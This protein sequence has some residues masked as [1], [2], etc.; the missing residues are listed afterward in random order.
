VILHRTPRPPWRSRQRIVTV[1]L[2]LVAAAAAAAIAIAVGTTTSGYR[3][4]LARNA[5]VVKTIALTGTVEPV[6]RVTLSFGVSGTVATVAVHIGQRVGAGQTVAT[7]ATT[8]LAAQVTED[9][10]TL[11][12]AQATVTADEKGQ[13]G[14]GAS[15]GPVA[16]ATSGGGP[17][18]SS[19]TSGT[20]SG[21]GT[22]TTLKGAQRAVVAAQK[23]ADAAEQAAAAALSTADTACGTPPPTTST[24]TGTATG[25]GTATGPTATTTSSSTSPQS[26]GTGTA[27]ATALHDA[28]AAQQTLAA[29]QR[30]VT[31]AESGLANV[32]AKGGSPTGP[33]TKPATGTTATTPST[34]G[35]PGGTGASS[36]TTPKDAAAQ[37]ASDQ[38]TVDTDDANLLTAQQSL[39]EATL[40]SPIS[41]TVGAVNIS[42]GDQTNGGVSTAAVTIV[43]QHTFEAEGLVSPTQVPALAVGDAVG[44]TVDGRPSAIAGH[45]TRIGPVDPT[46]GFQYPVVVALP[47]GIPR[48]FTGSLCQMTVIVHVAKRTLAV[49]TSAVHTSHG[50]SYVTVLRAGRAHRQSVAVGLVGSQETQILSGLRPGSQVVLATLTRPLP[51][52]SSGVSTGGHSGFPVP[53]PGGHFFIIGNGGNG[54][55]YSG[56][57]AG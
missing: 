4:V 49:P 19:S 5:P 38:A 57:P 44:V 6:S 21:S 42:K 9:K 53:F 32:L 20:S 26:A 56:G 8:S 16:A 34:A 30:A 33:G 51:K 10:A 55:V 24:G 12:A 31:R 28:L 25:A 36:P 54:V 52:P 47:A 35:A 29:D 37:L 46:L 41:G 13:A 48:L 50:R 27:C 2:V 14:G 7:L 40:T 3:T 43:T 22:P 18:G 17:G 23:T 39:A 15:T 1:A 11:R 45:V